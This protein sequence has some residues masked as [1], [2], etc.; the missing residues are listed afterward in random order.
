M[1]PKLVHDFFYVRLDGGAYL[2]SSSGTLNLRG[3]AVYDWIDRLAPLLDGEHSMSEIVAGASAERRGMIEQLVDV[4]ARNGMVTDREKQQ[5]HGLTGRELDVYA[6]EI[7]FLDSVA[8][9]GAHR[10]ERFR[11]RPVLVTG[12]GTSLTALTHAVLQL[13]AAEVD[14]SV[15][16]DDTA[17]EAQR[18]AELL[19]LLRKKDPRL[20]LGQVP[21]LTGESVETIRRRLDG[22]AAVIHCAD[23]P[24]TALVGYLNRAVAGTGTALL[25]SVVAHGAVW[26]GPMST[27]SPGCWECA[28]RRRLGA[29]VHPVR[30]QKRES[31][32]AKRM[33]GIRAGLQSS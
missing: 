31:R 8:G 19:A 27:A 3:H 21:A 1:R 16:G 26:L 28:W 10:F 14:V 9:S 17:A 33:E 25:Q 22:Y 18:R 7:A 24:S 5:P 6:E 20:R 29:F 15:D 13:G 4:L 23:H 12:S 32:I 2:K 11:Y 30:E